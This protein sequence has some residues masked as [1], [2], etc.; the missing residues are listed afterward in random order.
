[1]KKENQNSKKSLESLKGKK[2][3]D[4]KTVYAGLQNQAVLDAEMAKC[5]TLIYN[6][7]TA[8][9]SSWDRK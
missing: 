7:G 6:G 1:M 4:L 2:L 9:D 5:I 3:G 8:D